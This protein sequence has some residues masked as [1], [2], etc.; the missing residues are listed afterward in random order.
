MNN[1]NQDTPETI[2]YPP[3]S[4][5]LGSVY[6][7][8]VEELM[9]P[10]PSTAISEWNF[11]NKMVGGFRA[12]EY[13]ILCGPTGSGKTALLAAWSA[14]LLK[15]G[16]RQFVCSVENGPTDYMKRVMSIL[17][18]RDLN[19]GDPVSPEYM[20]D[21]ANKQLELVTR[22]INC[23]QF[24]LHEDRFSVEQLMSDIRYM[25]KEKGVK[26]VFIDNLNFFMKPTR[27]SDMILE[28]DRVT[29]ELIIL[30]KSIDVHIVMVMHPKKTDGGRIESEFDIKGSSTAVQE[31]HNVFLFNRID[32]K[33]FERFDWLDS[34]SRELKISKLRRRGM[35]AGKKIY[36]EFKEGSYKETF[37]DPNA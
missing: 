29:H 16:V 12:R 26:I 18:G 6:A 17:H 21:V 34:R 15:Q 37:I 11:F 28:M 35:Y 5:N 30:C 8:A 23:I 20:A 2:V 7:K 24:S 4:M 9:T 22:D 14:Q 25:V 10:Y 36:L 19:T 31:A 13:S 1:H 27:S 32:V 3:H 33:T